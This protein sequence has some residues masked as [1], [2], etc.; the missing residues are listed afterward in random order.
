MFGSDTEWS[1][2][3]TKT[4]SWEPVGSP[5]NRPGWPESGSERAPLPPDGSGHKDRHRR[6]KPTGFTG[7][8]DQIRN[9]NPYSL[10][11]GPAEQEVEAT[12][13]PEPARR[14][15]GRVNSHGGAGHNG[16]L[17]QGVRDPVHVRV[18]LF[19]P[20][21]E[22]DGQIGRWRERRSG[23]GSDRVGPQLGGLQEEG[24]AGGTSWKEPPESVAGKGS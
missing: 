2:S 20:S 19:H 9:G 8:P 11:P 21:D 24:G 3:W 4:G 18:A 6:L 14:G 5:G 13:R 12:E 7:P 10:F 15:G 1:Y 23:P 16:P 22:V 17:R